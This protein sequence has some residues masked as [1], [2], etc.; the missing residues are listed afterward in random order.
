MAP[1]VSERPWANR[2]DDLAY[3]DGVSGDVTVWP[4]RGPFGLGQRLLRV[5]CYVTSVENWKAGEIAVE[6]YFKTCKAC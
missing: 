4:H 1:W 5:A 2:E 3:P 6:M